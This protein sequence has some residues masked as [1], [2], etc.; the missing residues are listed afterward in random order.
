MFRQCNMHLDLTA[1]QSGC[2]NRFVR[3]MARLGTQRLEMRTLSLTGCVV[4]LTR[5]YVFVM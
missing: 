5:S 3:F 4:Q 1:V 2:T